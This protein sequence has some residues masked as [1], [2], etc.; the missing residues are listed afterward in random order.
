MTPRPMELKAPPPR[1]VEA[2]ARCPSTI[3]INP[4]TIKVA[5]AESASHEQPRIFSSIVIASSPAPSPADWFC[6]PFIWVSIL[7]AQCRSLA[8]WLFQVSTTKSIARS[9]ADSLYNRHGFDHCNVEWSDAVSWK[10][11]D[12]AR[13]RRWRLRQGDTQPAV[14]ERLKQIAH[15]PAALDAD[16]RRLDAGR[17]SSRVRPSAMLF[18]IWYCGRRP[19]SEPSNQRVMR[20][21]E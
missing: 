19:S 12:I 15:L 4:Y 11:H 9:Y 17:V 21:P 10:V 16:Q 13:H 18:T 20:S 7:A 3:Q 1:K 8:R 5:A 2:T 14:L 6:L